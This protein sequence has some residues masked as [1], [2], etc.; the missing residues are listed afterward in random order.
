M[1]G[2]TTTRRE[3]IVDHIVTS[4]SPKLEPQRL[5]DRCAE[6]AGVSAAGIML[7]SRDEPWG[8]LNTVDL[9][10]AR[11]EQ[12]Q[13]SLG[14]GP[15]IDAFLHGVTVF[16]PDLNQPR[17]PRWPSFSAPAV[18]AGVRAVFG[19]PLR[20]GGVRLGALDL[21]SDR[22]GLLKDEQ[23]LD[24]LILADVVARA[25]LLVQAAAPPTQLVA[26][27]R[28]PSDY[29]VVVNQASGMAAVQLEVSVGAAL[30]RMRVY[31]FAVGRSFAE[32]AQDVVARRLR[33]EPDRADARK[34]QEPRY[35]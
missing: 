32:V 33:F 5:R 30:I 12:L 11:I 13:F 2:M 6:V 28:S 20:V 1:L 31:A 24:A 25:I 3:A 14:E 26:E 19:F 7:M 23:H 35:R 15:G 10:G 29:Q 16:E 18:K 27:L 9:I 4:V 17:S 8:S 21:H 22:P 34:N